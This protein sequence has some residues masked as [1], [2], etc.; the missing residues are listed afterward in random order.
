[1]LHPSLVNYVASRRE[2]SSPHFSTLSYPERR[3]ANRRRAEELRGEPEEM[4]EVR[5]LKLS[6]QGRELSSRLYIPKGDAVEALIIF[7]HGGSFVEGDLETHDT[8]VRRLASQ[9]LMR[10]LAIDYR[11]APE[12]PFPASLDDARDVLHYVDQNIS[13]FADERSRIIMMGDSAGANLVAVTGTS[14]KNSVERLCAQVLI[15]PTLGPELVTGSAHEFGT[16]YLCDVDELRYDYASYLGGY[17]DHSDPRV[18]PLMSTDLHDVVPTIVVIAE[19]DPLR[20]EGLAYAGLL[21]HFNVHV[22]LLEAKGM[23]HSFMRLASIIPEARADMD[24]LAQH[25][26][27]FVGDEA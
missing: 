24:D 21:E 14:V 17:L 27:R 10:F 12:H 5:E 22:V 20:D 23:I 16:G 19:C 1:M 4:A 9:T 11:L 3:T 13:E 26:R 2:A 18:S 7:F 15:Y 8:L 6:L 25:L